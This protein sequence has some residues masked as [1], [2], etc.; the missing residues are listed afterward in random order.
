[1]YLSWF[2]QSLAGESLFLHTSSCNMLVTCWWSKAQLVPD[3]LSADKVGTLVNERSST[4][5]KLKIPLP[6]YSAKFTFIKPKVFYQFSLYV[7]NIK[8]EIV[9]FQDLIA[10]IKIKREF[11]LSAFRC[12]IHCY[13]YNYT[14]YYFY[15]NNYY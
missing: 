5:I 4:L 12:C 3:Q 1:M 6:C 13:H 8:C 11:F 7:L 9:G 10:T 14:Y 15:N 2:A